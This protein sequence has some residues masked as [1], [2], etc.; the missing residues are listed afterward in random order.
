MA[1]PTG[2]SHIDTGKISDQLGETKKSK[3]WLQQ[4][5]CYSHGLNSSM[6]W[7]VKLKHILTLRSEIIPTAK[8]KALLFKH[9][10]INDALFC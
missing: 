9:P 7:G 2:N 10:S 6:G 4:P 5:W 8:M 1:Y 3:A